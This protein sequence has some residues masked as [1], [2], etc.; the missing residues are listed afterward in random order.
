MM[1]LVNNFSH[2]LPQLL[3]Q[4]LSQNNLPQVQNLR[5]VLEMSN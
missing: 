1:A 3:F 2:D 4:A 5:E